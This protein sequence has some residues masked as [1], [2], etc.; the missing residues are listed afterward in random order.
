MTNKIESR[1]EELNITLPE[2]GTPP[3]NFVAF[4]RTGNLLYVS[5]QIPIRDGRIITGSVGKDFDVE[6]ATGLARLATLFAL[7][8]AKKALPSLDDIKQVVKVNGSVNAEKG[9]SQQPVVING[10]SDLLVEVFGE[11]GRNARAAVGVES[12][13]ANV[14]VEIEIIFEVN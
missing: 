6:E 2:V 3:S 11:K 4:I 10:C 13:P 7:A 5:G 12:L 9:F 8:V 14:P 1:L